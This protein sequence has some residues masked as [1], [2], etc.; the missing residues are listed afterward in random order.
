MYWWSYIRNAF[1]LISCNLIEIKWWRALAILFLCLQ[2]LKFCTCLFFCFQLCPVK[3]WLLN[4]LPECSLLYIWPRRNRGH[5]SI[6]SS[7][8]TRHYRKELLKLTWFM[9]P[10]V[11][12]Q[13]KE[14]NR[15][16]FFQT[17]VCRSINA[18]NVYASWDC[19][20]MTP[21]IPRSSPL[22]DWDRGFWR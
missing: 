15:D 11:R 10:S 22:P 16:S 1:V 21:L 17:A 18:D 14:A 3:F 9:S 8:L 13:H 12:C 7:S 19:H 6:C 2:D 20:C 4:V 5:M